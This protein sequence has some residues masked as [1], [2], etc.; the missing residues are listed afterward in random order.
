[1]KLLERQADE[2]WTAKYRLAL[3]NGKAI[4]YLDL[5]RFLEAIDSFKQSLEIDRALN[6]EPAMASLFGWLG[7]PTGVAGN[8]IRQCST[9]KKVL[10]YTNV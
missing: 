4:C 2:Q 1:M 5:N 3:L 9:M 6:D 7:L 8:S 10:L